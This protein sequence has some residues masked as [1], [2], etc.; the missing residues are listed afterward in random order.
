ML[1]LA[2]LVGYELRPG[3]AAS[4]YLSYILEE[5]PKPVLPAGSPVTPVSASQDGPETLI[6]AGALAQSVPGPGELPQPFETSEDLTARAAWNNLQVRLTRPQRPEPFDGREDPAW[7]VALYFQGIATNLKP[8][9]ALLI[10][11]DCLP[12][13][14][15]LSTAHGC[16][17]EPALDRTQVDVEPWWTPLREITSFTAASHQSLVV[18]SAA[19]LQEPWSVPAT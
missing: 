6:P 4:V 8:N 11:T 16:D 3:V 2:R 15:R 17:A 14:C 19:A 12:N 18:L 9:D 7:P 1:E 10:E 13:T 5:K